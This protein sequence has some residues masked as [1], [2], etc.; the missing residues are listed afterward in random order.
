MRRKKRS[1]ALV[2]SPYSKV[3]KTVLPVFNHA[4]EFLIFWLWTSEWLLGWVEGGK[5]EVCSKQCGGE[6]M[7]MTGTRMRGS[8]RKRKERKEKADN[9]VYHSHPEEAES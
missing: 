9:L 5:R 4:H 6:T 3:L 8:R 1:A 2:C 7:M